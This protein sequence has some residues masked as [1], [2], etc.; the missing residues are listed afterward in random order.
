[1]APSTLHDRPFF[2][3]KTRG[4]DKAVEVDLV[5]LLNDSMAI[6]V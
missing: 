1:M 3:Q 6:M 5:S 4:M 2:T